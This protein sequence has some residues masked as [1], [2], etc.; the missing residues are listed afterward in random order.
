MNAWTLLSRTVASTPLA[1]LP[2]RVRAGLAKGARWTFAPFSANWRFGGAE[3]DVAAG[4]RHLPGGLRGAVFWD[5]GAHYGIHTVGIALHAGPTGQVAAFEPDPAAFARL[6]RHV[7]MNRLENVRL[8]AAGASG[9]AGR[10]T[11]FTY[12]SHGSSNA[13]LIYDETDDMSGTDRI[14]IDVVAPDDLVAGGTIRLPDLVKVDV[15]GHGAEALA[16][17]IRS[18]AAGRPVIVFSNH[19]EAERS[20]TRALLEPLGY[21]PASLDGRTIGW[22]EMTECLLLPDAVPT[23]AP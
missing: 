21:R 17:S 8:I 19:S 10:R 3:R 2:V 6:A 16:G 5:F 14:E 11:L 22:E 15:Q 20:G 7:R 1:V 4:V 9:R 12:G 18:I 13:H 23:A